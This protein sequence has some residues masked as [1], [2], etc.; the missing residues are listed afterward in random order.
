[1][2]RVLIGF[3]K[4]RPLLVGSSERKQESKARSQPSI[5]W[6]VVHSFESPL[7]MYWLNKKR[8]SKPIRFLFE[9]CSWPSRALPRQKHL[10]VWK[11]RGSSFEGEHPGFIGFPMGGSFGSW[12]SEGRKRGA[13][14]GHIFFFFFFS[15]L[16]FFFPYSPFTLSVWW[17]GKDAR[18]SSL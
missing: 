8:L 15:S 4:V 17:R 12:A 10:T 18:G 6:T 1:L 9:P 7:D 5:G 11:K 14:G 2:K 3:Y 13:L 16:F